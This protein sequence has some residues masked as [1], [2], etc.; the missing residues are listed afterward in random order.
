LGI[1]AGVVALLGLLGAVS[2][3]SAQVRNLLKTSPLFGILNRP[4]VRFLD[5][6]L[7]NLRHT[8]LSPSD[9]G[10]GGPI[11][12]I[13]LFDPMGLGR[14]AAGNLYVSDR[15]GDGPGHVVWRLGA[16]GRAEIIAGTGRR[17]VAGT[18]RPAVESSL[19]SPQ[20]ICVDSLGRVYVADSYNHVV[21]RIERDGRLT[22]FAGTGRPG[23][24]GD[25]GPASKAE[26]NQPY[27]VSL[28]PQGDLYIADFGNHRIRKVT[29]D[30]SMQT[31]AGTGK[32]GYSGDGGP[33]TKAQLNGPYGV[34][35]EPDGSFLIGD[36]FNNAIR[37]VDARGVI[38]TLAGNGRPGYGGDG[39]PARHALLDAPQ[40]IYVDSSGRTYIGDEHNHSIRLVDATGVISRFAGTGVVGFSPDGTPA[41]AA[42]LNDPENLMVW[43]NGS[44]L[45]TEAG[46]H[47]VRIISREGRLSTLAGGH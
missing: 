19:G 26:L 45:F 11:S 27:D 17:G 8:V 32:S 5:A 28:A 36:S 4:A 10:T 20:S 13:K 35:A 31:V 14:D 40:S 15:G 1:V 23:R 6:Y 34:F 7:F 37:K 38:H 44:I 43:R 9:M 42:R 41:Q 2:L 47:R 22:R 12:S 18:G 21:V 29:P 33:A 3:A 30:G 39:G 46:N 16:D 24:D 25:G